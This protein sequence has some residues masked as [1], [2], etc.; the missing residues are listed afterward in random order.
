MSSIVILG[1]TGNL[2][3]H[4]VQQAHDRDWDISM[5]VRSPE[6]SSPSIT[7]IANLATFDLTDV[8]LAQLAQ[9]M[10][11]HDALV[12]CAGLVTQ[13]EVFVRLIDRVVTALESIGDSQRPIAWFM[14]GAALLDLDASHRRGVDLPKVR[15][16]YWPHR[17]NHERLQRS[18]LDWRL[19][20]PGPMVDQAALGT[21]RLRISLDQLPTPLPTIAQR[22]PTPML[23]P[24]F[25]MKVPEMIISY[26][27]AAAVMLDNL[28]AKNAMTRR[29]VGIAL[30]VG[31][32]GTKSEW[33]ARGEKIS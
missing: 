5:V 32:R 20:C 27:D 19:L 15:D 14:A 3:R 13:G 24:L 33:A 21:E 10:Q 25:A 11:G 6:K 17:A 22:L 30:P 31:M 12:C 16:T 8:P 4:V 28:E 18:K 29:R 2:G 23:L 7:P 1:A 9:F 26:A